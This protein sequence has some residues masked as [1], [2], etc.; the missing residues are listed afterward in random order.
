[1]RHTLQS[2]LLSLRTG[3]RRGRLRGES[4][5][6][7]VETALALTML[8]A[9]IIGVIEL[10]WALYSFHFVSE[11]AREGTRYAMVR[12]ADWLP[13]KCDPS[14][15]AGQGYASAAC[16]ASPTD[17]GNYVQSLDFPGIFISSNDVFVCYASGLQQ[18]SPCTANETTTVP[19]NGQVVEVTISYP[20]SFSIPGLKKYT[21]T[22]NSTSQMMIAW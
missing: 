10:S 17:I 12:G 4:G 9:L 14:G 3:G 15:K 21:Y 13:T 7:L 8:F 20:F 6:T 11:A 16:D 1:M 19:G 5:G 18:L 2:A 22:L